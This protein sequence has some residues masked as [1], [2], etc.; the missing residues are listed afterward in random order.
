[1]VLTGLE[2]LQE[3]VDHLFFV[4][5]FLKQIP[6]SLHK[7]VSDRIMSIMKGNDPNLTTGSPTLPSLLPRSLWTYRLSS[8]VFFSPPPL[9]AGS[10]YCTRVTV[11]AYTENAQKCTK[12][13]LWSLLRTI[14]ESPKLA[15]REK[16]RLLEQFYKG[17]PEIFIQYFGNRLSS[18]NMLLQWYLLVHVAADGGRVMRT[19]KRPEF[20]PLNK[21]V[22]FSRAAIRENFLTFFNGAGHLMWTKLV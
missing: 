19:S 7:L 9:H 11:K 5:R 2:P 6:V 21:N 10:T 1:M 18:I 15:A 3:N 4:F 17:H 20:R 14:H 12:E 22:N 13:E 16:R 8:A